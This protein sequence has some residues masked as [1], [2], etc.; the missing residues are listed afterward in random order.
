MGTQKYRSWSCAKPMITAPKDAL[1]KN[2]P[3]DY[4]RLRLAY[5]HWRLEQRHGKGRDYGSW[6]HWICRGGRQPG[7]EIKK[8]DRVSIIRFPS[9]DFISTLILYHMSLPFMYPQ[10]PS[11]LYLL[12]VDLYS[13]F[14]TLCKVLNSQL[15]RSS[16]SPS[17]PAGNAS[18]ARNKSTLYATTPTPL[19]KWNNNTD[20]ASPESSATPSSRE[21]APETKS[22]TAESPTPT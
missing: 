2:L 11:E 15:F 16:F 6:S 5:V 9:Q 18:T 19:K 13:K 22:N 20:T 21:A 3:H 7:A 12:F 10:K 17:F 8:G 4:L 14:K 1:V